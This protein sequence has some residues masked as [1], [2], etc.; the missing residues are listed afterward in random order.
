MAVGQLCLSIS[1]RYG[2]PFAA[3]T[4][5]SLSKHIQ[6]AQAEDGMGPAS[7]YT[8]SLTPAVEKK[9]Y[10]VMYFIDGVHLIFNIRYAPSL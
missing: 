2:T 6:P 5:T 7:I 3:S 1:R 4:S 9:D 8:G 10:D